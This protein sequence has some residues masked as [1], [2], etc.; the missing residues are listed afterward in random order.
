MNGESGTGSLGFRQESFR[1]LHRM[2]RAAFPFLERCEDRA[3]QRC[4]EDEDQHDDE[5]SA[6]HAFAAP[7]NQGGPGLVAQDPPAI[8]QRADGAVVAAAR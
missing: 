6:D 2:G 8:G 4:G 5:E 3:D 1:F 7:Q